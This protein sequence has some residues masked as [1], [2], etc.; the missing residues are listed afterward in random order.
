M[1]YRVK[2]SSCN[3]K[4]RYIIV[5]VWNV[6]CTVQSQAGGGAYSQAG[7]GAY[8]QAGG[9]AYRQAGGGAYSTTVAAAENIQ[10]SMGREWKHK[11]LSIKTF[12]NISSFHY[13]YL[14]FPQPSKPIKKAS[15]NGT[16]NT[17]FKK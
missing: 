7:G 3:V 13:F 6:C 10:V 5:N 2:K 15:S 1:W 4:K 8:R 12:N 14:P 17:S 16:N 9:G 11:Q